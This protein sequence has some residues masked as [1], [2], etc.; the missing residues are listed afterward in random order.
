MT[1]FI[2]NL[3][4]APAL[5]CSLITGVLEF[6]LPWMGH[7]A[8]ELDY[9]TATDTPVLLSCIYKCWIWARMMGMK[10]RY[11]KSLHH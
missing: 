3:H 1:F 9:L 10:D 8:K 7:Q 6:P 11:D 4:P 2:G 5:S